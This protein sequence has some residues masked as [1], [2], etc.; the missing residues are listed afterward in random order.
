MRRLAGVV[1]VILGMAAAVMAGE[2]KTC[3]SSTQD[4]LNH[5]KAYFAE[6]GWLGIE[7]DSETMKV[8]Q[9]I[10]GSPAERAGLQKGDL[11]VALNGVPLDAGN[12]EQI[13]Q[14]QS[15]QMKPGNKVQYTVERAGMRSKVE[16]TLV[17][18]PKEVLVQW[19]GG[20]MLEAHAQE[21]TL[22]SADG[23]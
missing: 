5:M 8:L 9:V 10:A 1:V 14:I 12:A 20:H 4:C 11:L 19:V 17:G 13:K 18:I 2:S 7:Y 3:T 6:R 23:G 22:A 21:M 15:Q 16:V